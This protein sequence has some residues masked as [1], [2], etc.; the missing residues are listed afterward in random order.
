[1][2]MDRLMA[3]LLVASLFVAASPAAAVRAAE[4][5]V[6]TDEP[7][8]WE[9][10]SRMSDLDEAE[11]YMY[12]AE[13]AFEEPEGPPAPALDLERFRGS[14]PMEKMLN[15]TKA[16]IRQL[17]RQCQQARRE[18]SDPSRACEL[19]IVNETCRVRSQDLRARADFLRRFVHPNGDNRKAFTKLGY[20]ISRDLRAAWYRIGPAGRRILRPIGDQIKDSVMG[21]YIPQAGAIRTFVKRMVVRGL[22]R[23]GARMLDEAFDRFIERA[24]HMARSEA[25]GVCADEQVTERSLTKGTGS[26]VVDAVIGAPKAYADIVWGQFQDGICPYYQTAN[27]SLAK[28]DLPG[29]RVR[30]ELDLSAGTFDGVISGQTYFKELATG[31]GWYTE[32]TGDFRLQVTAGTLTRDESGHGW[33]LTGEGA[34]AVGYMQSAPC[35]TSADDSTLVMRSQRGSDGMIVPIEGG[36]DLIGSDYVLWLRVSQGGTP[37]AADGSPDYGREK[38]FTVGLR[39]VVI[40]Q[41]EPQASPTREQ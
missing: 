38:R 32:A 3:A 16:Q 23:E 33:A 6:G 40:G 21:G 24:T 4:P 29:L 14:S 39:D 27:P 19:S 11:G 12:F 26:V 13:A 2:R 30:L 10:E 7:A 41:Y 31:S 18:N 25:G 37:K 22:K 20:R 35:W 5:G 8:P 28:E 15:A 36:I 1:M 34:T 17:D 9:G